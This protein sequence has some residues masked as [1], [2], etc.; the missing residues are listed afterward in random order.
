MK[1]GV[2]VSRWQGDVDWQLLADQGVLWAGIR[3]GVGSYYTDRT[4]EFN[5]DTAAEV[6]ILP[7]PYFVVN[8]NNPVAD[9]LTR[10]RISLDGRKPVATI[11][12]VELVGDVSNTILRRRYCW[13]MRDGMDDSQFGSFWMLYTNKSFAEAH[14]GDSY[15]GWRWDWMPLHV[16]SY[17]ANDG[18]VPP[19]PPYPRL[20]YQ[21]NEE[22]WTAWQYTDKGKLLGGQAADIDEDLMIDSVYTNLR[23]RSGIPEP[24]G[25][26]PQPPPEDPPGDEPTVLMPGLYR[27]P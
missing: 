22:G 4:F 21:W 11:C 19:T 15:Q 20:P 25:D 7:I 16:A 5:Y 12:D 17:G 18:N 3:A 14:L 9:Q 23:V 8:P 24:G 6:G 1:L 26:L 27:V 2:D 10:Y 13:F